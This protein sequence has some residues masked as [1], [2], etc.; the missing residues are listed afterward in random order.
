MLFALLMGGRDWNNRPVHAGRLRTWFKCEGDAIEFG[1]D[2]CDLEIEEVQ[3]PVGLWEA[4]EQRKYFSDPLLIAELAAQQLQGRP[5]EQIEVHAES[6]RQVWLGAAKY[7][8]RLIAAQPGILSRCCAKEGTRLRSGEL[9][10]IVTSD[11]A[12]TLDGVS[13]PPIPSAPFRVV[14]RCIHRLDEGEDPVHQN[15]PFILYE[16]E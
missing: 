16:Q 1:D 9:L 2:L 4:R 12:E 15:G 10:A 13:K 11:S 5:V 7:D 14:E 3:A 8:M 6:L